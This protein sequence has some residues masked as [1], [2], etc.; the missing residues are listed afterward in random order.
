MDGHREMD[1]HKETDILDIERKRN[2]NLGK[3]CE[4]RDKEK[5][6]LDIQSERIREN[7]KRK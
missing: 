5:R 7:R 4:E 2:D 6:K 3:V 1:R